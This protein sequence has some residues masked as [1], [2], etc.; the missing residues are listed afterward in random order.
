[1]DAAVVDGTTSGAHAGGDPILHGN[2]IVVHGHTQDE[3]AVEESLSAKELAALGN[4]KSFCSGLLKKLAP[5]LLKEIEGIWG[6]QTG[7][8]SFT[9]RRTTRSVCTSGSRKTKATAAETVL[10]KTLG[11]TSDDLAV[12][13]DAL[14]QLRT[15]FDSSV[16]EH[17]L[18]AI[19]AIFGK[20]IPTNLACELEQTMM[21]S[22]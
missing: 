17:Q 1:M 2:E 7:Q 16:Q 11:I 13:D 22:V 10:L 14:G 19:A 4:I 12:S 5:P 18:T 15:M 6:V 3:H 8:D 20:I 9:P 21:L